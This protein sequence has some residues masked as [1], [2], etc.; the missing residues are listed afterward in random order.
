MRGNRGLSGSTLKIIAMIS[1]LTDH[2]A[3]VLEKNIFTGEANFTAYIIMRLWI[4]RI[5]F[6]VFC[7]LLVEGFQRTGS[8]MKYAFRL[9]LFALLSEIPFDLAFYGEMMEAGYQNVF[10]TLWIGLLMM[11]GVEKI[12]KECR[13]RWMALLGK[14]AVF[15]AAVVLAELISC[16]YGAKGVTAIMLLYLFRR[17]K[18]EQI[19]A[20]CAGFIWEITAL[21]AFIPIAFYNGKRGMKLKYVFYVFYPAHLLLLYFLKTGI[22]T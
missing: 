17:N 16:D 3:A 9:F 19:I 15:A 14:A 22:L 10:F 13:N 18:K 2:T 4:G 21:L 11:M 8:R 20:G 12:E 1:M 7:F 5:A 6:P